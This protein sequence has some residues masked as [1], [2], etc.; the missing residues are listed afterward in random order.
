LA[1]P[2]LA[3]RHRQTI[4]GHTDEHTDELNERVVD[5]R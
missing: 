5:S 4:D 3:G 2:E 1:E